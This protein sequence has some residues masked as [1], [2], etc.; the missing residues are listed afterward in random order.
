MATLVLTLVLV[1]LAMVGLAI[2]YLLRGRPLSG[3]CGSRRHSA[4]SSSPDPC[5]AC[6]CERD[7]RDSSPSGPV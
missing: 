5:P 2:G 4:V 1:A 7:G 6:T 3:G